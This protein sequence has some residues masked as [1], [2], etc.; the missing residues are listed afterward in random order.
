MKRG[1]GRKTMAGIQFI[2]F[3]EE[4]GYRANIDVGTLGDTV[5]QTHPLVLSDEEA[6]VWR[7]KVIKDINSIDPCKL[8]VSFPRKK[9][10]GLNTTR[11]PILFRY[12]ETKTPTEYHE[13]VVSL[14]V[15]R[16]EAVDKDIIVRLAEITEDERDTNAT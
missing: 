2:R 15:I 4:N 12:D 3:A 14:Y 5:K 8:L 16:A 6:Q 11:K 10:G 1:K 9:R 13:H 7:E